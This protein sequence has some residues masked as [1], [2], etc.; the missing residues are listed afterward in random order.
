VENTFK[1]Q[2]II[3]PAPPPTSDTL[4]YYLIPGKTEDIIPEIFNY[5]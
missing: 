5:Y 2:V 1:K 3:T 4:P